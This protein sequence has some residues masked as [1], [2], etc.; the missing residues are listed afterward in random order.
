M[1]AGSKREAR[2]LRGSV[3]QSALACDGTR[4]HGDTGTR[5]EDSRARGPEGEAVQRC[6]CGGAACKSA[7]VEVVAPGGR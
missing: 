5:I 1:V 4:G 2:R 3:D 6:N 7:K